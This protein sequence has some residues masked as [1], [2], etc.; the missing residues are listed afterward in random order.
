MRKY[1]HLPLPLRY[2]KTL[3][4]L[5]GSVDCASDLVS[6]HDLTV[7]EFEPRVGV[8]ADGSEPGARLRL[9]PSLSAPPLLMLS[10]PKI[11]IK[12]KNAMLPIM[13]F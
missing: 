5:G 7:R 10:L 11:N 8:C 2:S 4:C 3:G 1:L 6:G 9:S 12:K 13:Q